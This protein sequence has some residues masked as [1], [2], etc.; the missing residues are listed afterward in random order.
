MMIEKGLESI[1]GG[2][3]AA[4]GFRASGVECGVK[5][6][7]G[8]DLALVFS[9]HPA[10]AA[11]V[12]TTNRV[13]AAPVTLSRQ[14]LSDGKARAVILNS[15]N[16]NTCL[17]E[18]GMAAAL[19][20]AE[21]TA[22]ALSLSAKD[23]LVASTGVIGAAF[24][25]D[26]V[27]TGIPSLV[28]QLTPMGGGLAA[29]AIMTTDT[30]SKEV[31]VAFMINDVLVRVGGMAK[32]SGMIQPNMATML[33][34][35]T[36]D[37]G[38]PVELLKRALKTATRASFNRIT[39]DG[40]TSTNDSLFLLANGAS[41]ARI[42]QVDE[43]YESFVQA[44]TYVCTELAKMCVRDGEGATKLV[45]IHLKNAGSEENAAIAA[46]SVGNSSLVKTAF[47]G[48]D[49]NWGRII[50]AVGYSGIDFDPDKTR[51][52]LGDLPVYMDGTGLPFDEERAKS[53]L[54]QREFEVTVDLGGDPGEAT[55]W[56]C[57]FSYDYVKINGSYRS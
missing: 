42:E 40:D 29:R 6:R 44:L 7:G 37:L 23:I 36:T 41:G 51:I 17:G 57:D 5:K 46:R 39:I 9:D 56:T 1:A 11:G 12:F 33:S 30:V 13:V 4:R 54:S 14:H 53:I 34:V 48:E 26:K 55:V 31:A 22:S 18:E 28:D 47:F 19:K 16:A 21:V 25:I 52:F 24:P 15:G 32:G 20:M 8:L 35:V 10:D 43:R 50:C 45:S 38:M 3:T 49:A 2:V 27:V